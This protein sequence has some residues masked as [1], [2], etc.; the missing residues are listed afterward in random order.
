MNSSKCNEE[1]YVATVGRLSSII[2]GLNNSVW[3]KGRN[4]VVADRGKIAAIYACGL[5]CESKAIVIT[6]ALV[7]LKQKQVLFEKRSGHNWQIRFTR[8]FQLHDF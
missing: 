8:L 2:A 5:S 4:A 6:K 1:D 7:G 3:I